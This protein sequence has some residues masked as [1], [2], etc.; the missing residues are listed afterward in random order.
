MSRIILCD[1]NGKKKRYGNLFL[2]LSVA[3]IIVTARIY[4]YLLYLRLNFIT[5]N[6]SPCIF[7]FHFGEIL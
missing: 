1:S 3:V 6:L 7:I 5:F 4:E 2:I